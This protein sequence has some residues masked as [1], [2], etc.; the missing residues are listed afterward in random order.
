M[1]LFIFNSRKWKQLFSV[2]KQIIGCL[3]GGTG[4]PRGRWKLLDAVNVFT[5]S[6]VVRVSLVYIY[7]K[8]Y[9]II[10]VNMFSWLYSNYTVINLCLK[11]LDSWSYPWG[12]SPE[13]ALSIRCAVS[14][15]HQAWSIWQRFHYSDES[16]VLLF[17][18]YDWVLLIFPYLFLSYYLAIWRSECCW[19]LAEAHIYSG[20]VSLMAFWE[21]QANQEVVC[22]VASGQTC[23]C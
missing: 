3:E 9:Y 21:L 17:W 15:A 23:C 20:D 18:L 14:W 8:I 7:V 13:S 6:I 2:R 12:S 4:R 5:I 19:L 1:S 22:L 16:E 11:R 10:Y